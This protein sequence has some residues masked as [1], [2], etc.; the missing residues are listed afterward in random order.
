[1]PRSLFAAFALLLSPVAAA[2]QDYFP[3]LLAVYPSGGAAGTTVEVDLRLSSPTDEVREVL[4]TGRGVTAAL[5]PPPKL[6]RPDGH[7]VQIGYKLFANRCG[8][9]HDLPNPVVTRKSWKEWDDTITRMAKEKGAPVEL[10]PPKGQHEAEAHFIKSYL[11]DATERSAG[12]RAK[13]T[14][15]ADAPPGRREVRVVGKTWTSLVGAF[16]VNRDREVLDA[17]D[18]HTPESAQPLALPVTVSGQLTGL[19]EVDYYAVAAKKGERLVAR[20]SAHRLNPDNERHFWPVL[21][22][23]D[24]GGKQLQKDTGRDGFDPLIDFTA[25]ADGT[26]L[27]SVRDLF[28]RGSPFVVYRLSVGDRPYEAALFP[29]GGR[30]GSTATPTL[31]GE[32]ARADPLKLAALTGEPGIRTLDTSHGPFPFVASDLPDVVAKPGEP[33]AVAAFPAALNGRIA[34]PGRADVFRFRVSEKEVPAEWAFQVFGNQ[35]GSPL[36]PELVLRRA[37]GHLLFDT[38]RD[39]KYPGHHLLQAFADGQFGRDPAFVYKFEHAGEYELAVGD[40][41]RRAG[42]GFVYRVHVTKPEPDFAVAVSP[43]NPV[44]RPGGSVYLELHAVRRQGV[45]GPIE[46]EFPHLPPDVTASRGVLHP[47]QDKSFVVLTAAPDAKPGAYVRT[48]PVAKATVGGTALARPTIPYEVRS[49]CRAVPR[50]DELV[51][52]VG[53][54][55]DWT[56]TADAVGGPLVPGGSVEVR[57]RVDRR[58]GPDRDMPFFAFADVPGV[59]VVGLP[60]VPKGRREATVHLK[61][62]RDA[63]PPGQVQFV[64]VTGL[65]E[66]VGVSSNVMNQA[67]A[68]LRVPLAPGGK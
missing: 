2:A 18:N 43:D 44:V 60:T 51:V 56:V 61:L 27:L 31:V 25:P 29:A 34:E 66:Y 47:G 42:P 32:N 59:Q 26:Y 23:H 14:I 65:N 48:L 39:V 16:E 17:A 35:I 62:S 53:A 4:V 38:A 8:T 45:T 28:A 6:H 1:M 24:A 22:V 9:C 50:R 13:L 41:R 12:V 3:T 11:V 37:D 30:L 57:I 52:T 54:P 68:P 40:V 19:R 55:C 33:T 20:I 49:H 63:R 36:A 64:L 67:S 5:V 10:V 21:A 58:G 7:H 15:A 46:V